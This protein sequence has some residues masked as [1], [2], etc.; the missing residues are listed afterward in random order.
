MLRK[1]SE[2]ANNWYLLS[3]EERAAWN[4]IG[5]YYQDSGFARYLKHELQGLK[6]P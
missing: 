2:A 4:L 5:T 1:F 6:A 3:D